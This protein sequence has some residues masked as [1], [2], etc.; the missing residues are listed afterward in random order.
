[1]FSNAYFCH[2]LIHFSNIL[3][4]SRDNLVMAIC[5]LLIITMFSDAHFDDVHE[6]FEMYQKF[7][8]GIKDNLVVMTCWL[9]RLGKARATK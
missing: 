5:W 3:E 2:V 6:H 1:M 7:V 4:D 9:H 8:L